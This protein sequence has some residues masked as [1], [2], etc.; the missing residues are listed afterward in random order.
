M[1]ITYDGTERRHPPGQLLPE[2]ILGHVH[3]LL[4]MTNI[5]GHVHYL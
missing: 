1:S 4:L 5:L 2:N 3:Y